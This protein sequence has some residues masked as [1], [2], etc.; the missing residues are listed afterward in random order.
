[1][2][3]RILIAVFGITLLVFVHELGHYLAARAVGMRVTR[4]SIGIGPV[5]ARFQPKGSPTVFQISAIPFMAYVMIAGMNPVEEVDPNDPAIYPNKNVFAR[6]LAIFGGPFA[7]YLAASIMVFG[8][9]MTVGNRE[10]SESGPLTVAQVS[11]DSPAANAG[12]K[13]D[14]V[15]LKAAG[16]PV[17]NVEQ[18]IEVTAPRAG[19]ATEYIVQR[20]GTLLPPMSITPED[21][22]GRGIIGV[23]PKY[24]FVYRRQNLV[25]GLQMAVTLPFKLTMLNLEGIFDLIERRSTEGIKGPVGM[26]RL[27]AEQVDKGIFD[28]VW[29]LIAISVALGLFNLFPLPALDGGKLV[30][31]IYEVIT[32]KRPNERIEATVHAVGLLFLFCVIVLVTWRDITS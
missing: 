3:D 20:D 18:L 13:P 19:Q 1:M 32:R 29:I 12:I 15:I 10:L 9:V 23:T 5:L 22:D 11:D 26:Y 24:E 30:F 31:L 25:D 17:D 4:F 27:V 28:V 2:I 7:N 21:H 6:M 8:L 14:D 16:R